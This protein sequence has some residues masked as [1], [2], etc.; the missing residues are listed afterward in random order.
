[1]TITL[2]SFLEEAVFKCGADLLTLEMLEGSPL[3]SS[4]LT[5]PSGFRASNLLCRGTW[6]TKVGQDRGHLCLRA[7]TCYHFSS[8]LKSALSDQL[9]Q[10]RGS[11]TVWG[12]QSLHPSVR[13]SLHQSVSCS[14]SLMALNL[15]I[16]CLSSTIRLSSSSTCSH[17]TQVA[18]LPS[19]L[20][21][22][23]FRH[24]LQPES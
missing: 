11:T 12:V 21:S 6:G 24:S 17:L 8:P 14:H 5:S 18:L 9:R 20:S 2:L 3:T 13:E 19:S 22:S 4:S 7:G 23:K 1:M 16:S 10:G 15:S